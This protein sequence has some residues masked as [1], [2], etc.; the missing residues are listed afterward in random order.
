[1]CLQ[2]NLECV[3][4]TFVG[5][6]DLFMSEKTY[7]KKKKKKKKTVK[8]QSL[9]IQHKNGLIVYR[10]RDKDLSRRVSLCQSVCL[11]RWKCKRTWSPQAIGVIN[12]NIYLFPEAIV[13]LRLG[14]A[15]VP[16]HNQ[17]GQF[18]SWFD[19]HINLYFSTKISIKIWLWNKSLEDHNPHR[20]SHMRHYVW[21][22]SR[23]ATQLKHSI[24]IPVSQEQSLK[25]TGSDVSSVHTPDSRQDLNCLASCHMEQQTNEWR[26]FS[27]AVSVL[28][29]LDSCH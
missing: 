22:Q 12:C 14:P 3:C 13:H 8:P 19:L 23:R 26:S 7:L 27:D 18:R 1:M 28:S 15:A 2:Y 25:L 24:T 17:S 16:L 6:T 21:L 9:S 20:I 4:R 10:H 11:S 29:L 5:Q